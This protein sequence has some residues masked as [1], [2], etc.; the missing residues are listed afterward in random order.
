MKQMY[1]IILLLICSSAMNAQRVQ[2]TPVDFN[3]AMDDFA[4]ELTRHD[5][6]MY[7]TSDREDGRQQVFVVEK[8]SGGW[9]APDEIEGRVN[10]G[11]QNGS[12]AITPDG[13]FM[14]F[15]AFEYPIAGSG[16]TD[17]YSARK[18]DG[19]WTDVENLGPTVNSEYWDSQPTISSDGNMLIFA[20]DR[21]GGYGGTDI[22]M[23]YRDPDGWSKPR[24]MGNQVNSAGEDMAP[25]IAWDNKTLYFASDRPGGIGGMDLYMGKIEG[26][27]TSGVKN[28]GAEINTAADEYFYNPVTNTDV[29]YFS[30]NRPGGS[31]ALDIYMAVPNPFPP[32]SVVMVEGK[33]RDKE[34]GDPIGARLIITD[35][36][37]GRAIA[38]MYSDDVNGAYTV[39][40]QPGGVYS[41]TATRPGYL[42]YSDRYEVPPTAEGYTLTNDIDLSKAKV[43]LLVF[44]DFDKATLKNESRPEL[45][46]VIEFMRENPDL[47]IQLHGHT[48][49]V[50]S[51]QYNKELS[52][53]RAKAVA[54]YLIDAGISGSRI[55]TKGFG[56]TQP[57]VEETTEE[58][59][60]KNRRVEMIIVK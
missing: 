26:K 12:V 45:E 28:L 16:R 56:K 2:I 48:D 57:L 32:Q 53:K 44:F 47:Q 18:V 52:E 14:V 41:I 31:G 23:C 1:I 50:G 7:F 46:R 51:P 39:V 29:A 25:V 34:T 20:S 27:N 9:T 22:W 10:V 59:R 24:N 60:A 38:D 11:I 17:L 40:L 21:P 3:S 36:T 30:S 43:R 35:L 6:F 5:R 58:A 8:T 33:V 49:D 37:T 19:R 42:F 55:S 54:D 15:A 4:P 13:Q